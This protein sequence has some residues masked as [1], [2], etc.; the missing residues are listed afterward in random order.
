[1]P[2]HRTKDIVEV[3]DE[4][5]TKAADRFHCA[6]LLPLQLLI[7]PGCCRLLPQGG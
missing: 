7:A 2:D 1:M 6:R 3:M 5:P 4:A